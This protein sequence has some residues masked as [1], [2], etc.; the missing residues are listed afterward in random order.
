ML[1]KEKKS[2]EDF[3]D[4][5]KCDLCGYKGSDEIGEQ[6]GEKFYCYSCLEEVQKDYEVK[7]FTCNWCGEVNNESNLNNISELSLCNKCYNSA[8]DHNLISNT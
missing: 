2:L 7:E 3:D 6:K 4:Y 5:F 8:K 1:S